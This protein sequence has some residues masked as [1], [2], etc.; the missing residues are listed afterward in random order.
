MWW[1]ETVIHHHPGR[2]APRGL[3]E[4]SKLFLSAPQPGNGMM[5]KGEEKQNCA[6]EMDLM[7]HYFS[8]ARSE[9]TVLLE[10]VPR[11][12]PTGSLLSLPLSPE[13]TFSSSWRFS[14]T[15]CL[16]PWFQAHSAYCPLAALCVCENPKQPDRT[17]GPNKCCLVPPPSSELHDK[18][19]P[20]T[21]QSP[22][23]LA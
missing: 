11:Q 21:L 10:P 16:P 12:P 1:L 2:V 19:D 6:G 8:D 7:A 15:A 20:I 4:H 18:R 13:L 17:W 23:Y 3:P 5:R 9:P 14:L 22:Q